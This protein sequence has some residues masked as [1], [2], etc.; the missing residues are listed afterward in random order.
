[1]QKYLGCLLV[2]AL[3]APPLRAAEPMGK[4]VREDWDAAYLDGQKA[5]YTRV[6][7]REFEKDGKKFFR[8]TMNL[9]LVLRRFNDT[10]E[11][12]VET[13]TDETADGKVVGVQMR[14]TLGKN[15]VLEMI[16]TVEGEQMLIKVTGN[17]NMEKKVKWNDK[18]I[19]L[20]KEQQLYKDKGVK[21][22]SEFSYLHFEPLI[23]AV[24]TINVTVGDYETVKV[25]G[26]DRKLLRTEAVPEKIQGVQLPGTSFW[27]DKDLNVVRSEVAMPGL[28]KLVLART[29]KDVALSPVVPAKISDIGLN[30]LIPLNRRI[31]NPQDSSN[32]VYKVTLPGDD[33][34]GTSFAKD[35]R[36][37]IKNI[38]GKTFELHVKAVRQ[39]PAKAT[40][41]AKVDEEY[42]KS[43]YF[44]TSA[45]SEV[46]K[47]AKKAVGAE[48][49]PWKKAQLIERWVRNNMKIQNFTEAMAT[50][51]HVARNLEG[52]CTE[53][54]MLAAAMCRAVGVPSK[55]AVGL[56]YVDGPK[57]VLG[58]HMW[59]EVW[60]RGEWVPIDAT[61]GKGSIGAA[62]LKISDHSWYD[63]QSL[64]PLLPVMR[65]M[66]AKVQIEVVKAE[67]AE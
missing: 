40:E 45:D 18:V 32:V 51:D 4:V 63:T 26:I 17:M 27:L 41:N 48:A 57:P 33:E 44:I 36:Q 52:D 1:M 64:K 9:Y 14:Q 21:A 30:Q 12:K 59:T 2:V 61:L 55:I 50:A 38:K 10:V 24:V 46:Q 65:V 13:G 42:L 66:L 39:P 22:G 19:G 29:T 31:Q 35:N 43:S 28:G 16:G 47:L 11:M 34:P 20:Y 60:V 67:G 5:G 25:N 58:Y 8:T 6:L 15:Q 53:H 56:V 3:A 37:D 62:H 7:V 54:A 49:D 23:G